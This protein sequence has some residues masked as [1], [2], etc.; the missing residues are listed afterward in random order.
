[1]IANNFFLLIM[2][3][4]PVLYREVLSFSVWRG[5]R[6]MLFLRSVQPSR[7]IVV[8]VEAV[9]FVGRSL[10]VRIKDTLVLGTLRLSH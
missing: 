7:N 3:Y 4:F 1:M 5:N 9:L 2:I 6:H 8:S 10:G